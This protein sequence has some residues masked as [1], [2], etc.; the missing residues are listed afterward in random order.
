MWIQVK[1]D[2]P[3]DHSVASLQ[4]SL[5]ALYLENNGAVAQLPGDAGVVCGGGEGR[6]VVGAQ[7]TVR[8]GALETGGLIYIVR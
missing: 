1:K 6:C 7:L 3:P 5:A 8:V 2:D 4:S